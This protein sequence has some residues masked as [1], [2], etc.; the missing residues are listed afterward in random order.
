MT[1]RRET[2]R[3]RRKPSSPSKQRPAPK[4]N[5]PAEEKDW[6]EG[7]R[8]AKYLARAGV[9]S[10]RE[11]ERMIEDGKIT[12][13]GVKLTSPAFKVTGRELIRVGRR[14]IEAPD[15]T[16]VWRYHKPAGLIT[17]TVDPEG[18]R[19]VFDELP[20]SL[21]RVV[22]VGR[23][24]LNTEGLLLLTNDGALAR[25]LEL[26]KNALE[27]TYRVRALGTVTT[28]KIAELAEGVTVD[29]ID[30]KPITAVL[31]R[32][33]GANSWLTVTLTEGKKREVRRALEAVNLKVN[34]LIRVQY[35]PFLLDDLRPGA[36]EEVPAELLQAAIGHLM[37]NEHAPR[38]PEPARPGSKPAP[39]S[40]LGSKAPSGKLRARKRTKP[41]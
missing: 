2:G 4:S 30:Y 25:A 11:V 23:L 39:K 27:R 21:P 33:T 29:G 13:D 19:T 14:I 36:V 17:T 6:S 37:T 26:P 18:R 28:Y 10:R 16:R 5:R 7:E 8:I 22:T 9:A 12:V 38:P 20:K 32:E 34:R 3:P 15:A 31:D 35:G 40:R 24:D 41:R 1:E